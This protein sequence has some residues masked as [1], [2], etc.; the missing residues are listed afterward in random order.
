MSSKKKS[1]NSLFITLNIF[2]AALYLLV[3]LVPII[4]SGI[5]WYLSMLGLIFPILLFGVIA[6]FIGWLIIRS[7]WALVSLTALL[8]SWQQ[9]AAVLSFHTPQT[10]N[11]AKAA[12][13]LRLLSWNVSSWDELNKAKKGGTSYRTLMFEEVKKCNADILCFQEFLES[14]NVL[15]YEPTIPE[16]QKMGYPY[17]FFLHTQSVLNNTEMGMVI[18]SKYPIIK[19]GSFDFD[20]NGTAQQVIYTDVKFND[21]LIRVITIHLQSVRFGKEE[22]I[23]LKEIQHSNKNGLKDSKTIVSKLKRAYPFRKKQA[24]MVNDFIRK[25]PYPVILCGDFND[26]PNSYTYFTVKGNLQDAFLE[27]GSGIGR[28]FRFIS[29]TLRIDYIF[30]DK[31]FEIIQYHRLTV[32]YSD[33]YGIIAD[34]NFVQPT[35][36]R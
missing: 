25:S 28:T 29:P 2:L 24:E 30:A 36:D 17:H 7:K 5:F 16:L 8:I 20:D 15:L 11:D 18:F 22:Y 3:C 6:F 35:S 21:Q 4:D 26:V 9:I 31:K 19:S 10:F 27:K 34:L 32:P 14:T 1:A 12:G 33:H 13:N 23:S